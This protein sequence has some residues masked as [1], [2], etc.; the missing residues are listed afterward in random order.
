MPDGGT[1]A[2][3]V[4]DAT[5]NSGSKHETHRER[6]TTQISASDRAIAPVKLKGASMPFTKVDKIRREDS[7][8][9]KRALLRDLPKDVS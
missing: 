1:K 3:S 2:D 6:V 4:I 9:P 5:Y 8:D 7:G